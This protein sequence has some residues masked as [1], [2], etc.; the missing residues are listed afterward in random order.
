MQAREPI[1]SNTHSK[2][3]FMRHRLLFA[4][5]TTHMPQHTMQHAAPDAEQRVASD[6]VHKCDVCLF[7]INR[8]LLGKVRQH[9]PM[10]AREPILSNT[11]TI[12]H[13]CVREEVLHTCAT[14]SSILHAT[15]HV[16]PSSDSPLSRSSASFSAQTFALND[17]SLH[18]NGN[19]QQIALYCDDL[20][21]PCLSLKT[22]SL[23][24]QTYNSVIVQRQPTRI[25]PKKHH[26]RM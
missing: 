7:S 15:R 16:P 23:L 17:R 12:N 21:P 5:G 3:S 20:P 14:R 22:Y 4:L 11:H 1:P 18:P 24:R 9:T 8:S 10:Q 26:A 6:V 13:I 25:R 2:T 19:P